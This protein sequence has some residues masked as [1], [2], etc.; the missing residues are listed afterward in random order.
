MIL[1]C[2]VTINSCCVWYGCFQFCIFKFCLVDLV[3]LYNSNEYFWSMEIIR[4]IWYCVSSPQKFPQSNIKFVLNVG[5]QK[6]LPYTYCIYYY[7]KWIEKSKFTYNFRSHIFLYI[8][9]ILNIIKII[10]IE[11]LLIFEYIKINIY[12]WKCTHANKWYFLCYFS[13]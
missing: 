4:T 7:K 1:L 3:I 6:N 10:N 13:Q 12:L 5:R 8:S 9:L 2:W 11:K